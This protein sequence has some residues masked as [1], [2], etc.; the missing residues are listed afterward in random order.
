M[1]VQRV[2]LLPVGRCYVSQS[3]LNEELPEGKLIHIPIW[4]YL[5]ETTDGPILIDTGMPDSYATDEPT[6]KDSNPETGPVDKGPIVPDFRPDE[7]IIS[8]LQRTGY[9]P[10][11]LLCVVNSHWH[12][13]HAGGNIHFPHTRIVVQKAEYNAAQENPEDYPPECR[14][15]GLHYDLI[16]GDHE[17]VPGMELLFT[18]GH[19]PG[20]MSV[21]L[22]TQQTG[23]ILL[24]ADA[25]YIRANFEEGAKFAV[26]NGKQAEASL[27]RLR[28]LA[29]EEK[30]LVFYG[31][32]V[33]QERDWLPYPHWY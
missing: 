25:A 1:T 18:P 23:K 21:Y 31:H 20:H 13:D 9:A 24:T 19:S 22:N 6:G 15:D 32:D 30:P 11:D 10:E 14:V 17:L 27:Q 29:K 33:H 28:E 16:E 3:M 2:A 4:S 7:G 8:V 5:V 26:A 12:F